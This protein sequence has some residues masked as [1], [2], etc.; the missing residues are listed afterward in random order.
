MSN[1]N[2]SGSV[3]RFTL[4]S[5]E[6]KVFETALG[7][8]SLTVEVKG[9]DQAAEAVEV[10]VQTSEDNVSFSDVDDVTVVPCGSAT[11][12]V[13]VGKYGRVISTDGE[14]LVH[15]VCKLRNI[16]QVTPAL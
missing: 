6:G 11:I 5:G 8:N 1:L 4:A 16:A 15:V 2:S 3:E 13:A 9:D 12:V 14:D 10:T 7:S